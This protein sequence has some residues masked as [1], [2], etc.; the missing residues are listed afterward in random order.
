MSLFEQIRLGQPDE[1]R[2]PGN[3]RERPSPTRLRRD[4]SPARGEGLRTRFL[5]ANACHSLGAALSSAGRG[6]NAQAFRLRGAI[7][8]CRTLPLEGHR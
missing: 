6:R 4:P 1:N 2:W 8:I 3:G 5:A 7:G